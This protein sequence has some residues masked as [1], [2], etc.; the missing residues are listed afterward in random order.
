[1][2]E[3]YLIDTTKAAMDAVFP[4]FNV[5]IDAERKPVAGEAQVHGFPVIALC[6]ITE[7]S[8][9]LCE[10]AFSRAPMVQRVLDQHD[11]MATLLKALLI[12][13]D[14]YRSYRGS[15]AEVEVRRLAVA[16][17]AKSKVHNLENLGQAL[18]TLT[19]KT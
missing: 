5:I 10:G 13:T 2:H 4:H 7:A 6:P 3:R 8:E 15:E 17:L 16:M 18:V 1:M 12:V 19:V 9:P 11:T 14:P